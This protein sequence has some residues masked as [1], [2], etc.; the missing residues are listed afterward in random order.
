MCFKKN[1]NRFN[2]SEE[3]TR[4]EMEI[5]SLQSETFD[6]HIKTLMQYSVEVDGKKYIKA[7]ELI[8]FMGGDGDIKKIVTGSLGDIVIPYKLKRPTGQRTPTELYTKSV[9]NLQDN[10]THYA[11][12]ANVV[13]WL[14]QEF[15]N[16]RNLQILIKAVKQVFMNIK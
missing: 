4:Q 3:K 11:F 2:E 1:F 14:E 8:E 13:G 6:Y 16:E 10:T 15:K 7:K 9:I 12:D 5:A